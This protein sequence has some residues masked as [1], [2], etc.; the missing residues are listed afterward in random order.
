MNRTPEEA[1]SLVRGIIEGLPE[2]SRLEI[3]VCPPFTSLGTVVRAVEGTGIA[4]GAQNL[5]WEDK[6]AFTGEISAAMLKAV[7]CKY[8]IIGHSERR[9]YFGE[10]DA[11]IRRKIIRVL[12]DDLMPIFC[13]GETL[14]ERERGST[15][16]VVEIQIRTGLEKVVIENPKRFFVAYEP[17]WA[18]G[19]GVTATPEQAQ[20]VH[21]FI[22]ELLTEMYGEKIGTECRILYG[23]SVTPDNARSILE[24]PDV[25]GA[26]V[27][28]ASLKVETFLGIIRHA[29]Q[30]EK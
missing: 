6:G 18:I 28:G 17:V 23:G 25:D 26:L 22:R 21:G 30:V 27:G 2:M 13:L 20:E 3:A 5:H 10:T 15:K 16:A 19:T 9:H 12:N 29:V 24:K 7:G 8:A 11:T 1:V 4:V 14:E